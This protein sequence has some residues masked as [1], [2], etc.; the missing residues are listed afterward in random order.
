MPT[1]WTSIGFQLHSGL[2]AAHF[3][4]LFAHLVVRVNLVR[5]IKAKIPKYRLSEALKTEFPLQMILL[6]V[7]Y[8]GSNPNSITNKI[9]DFIL[10]YSRIS[11]IYQILH[12]KLVK[13]TN[14]PR[15]HDSK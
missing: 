13:T 10:C 11:Q 1:S 9:L 7:R 14:V 8:I 2:Y 6:G 12:F 15:L 5:H 3:L 4:A